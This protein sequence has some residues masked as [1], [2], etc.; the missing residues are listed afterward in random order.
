MSN[1][2]L[3]KQWTVNNSQITDLEPEDVLTFGTTNVTLNSN[4]PW[5]TYT[6]NGASSGLVGSVSHGGVTYSLTLSLNG[7]L[8]GSAPGSGAAKGGG[9]QEAAGSSW[10]ANG[11]SGSPQ[12]VL[13]P[14]PHPLSA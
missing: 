6:S 5:G 1:Y 7:T 2:L 12:G 14:R 13:L 8:T 4:T 3:G 10:T 11:G 9:S